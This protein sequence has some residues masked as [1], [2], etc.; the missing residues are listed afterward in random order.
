MANANRLTPLTAIR[1]KCMDCCLGS[2]HEVRLCPCTDCPHYPY[3]FGRKPKGQK[4]ASTPLKAIKARCLDC[5]AYAPSCVR[6]C[7]FKHCALYPY[8]MGK[9]PKRAGI[10]CD[11]RFT[12]KLASAGDVQAH[13][14]GNRSETAA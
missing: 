8:R 13:D 12:A 6:E 4:P 3:R 2:S 14:V 10:G 1:L 11:P 9:N 5:G 7:E